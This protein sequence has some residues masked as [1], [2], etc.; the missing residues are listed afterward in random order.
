MTGNPAQRLVRRARRTRRQWSDRV[1]R[2]THELRSPEATAAPPA[3]ATA[4]EPAA[5]APRSDAQPP[6]EALTRALA[7]GR[8]L[9]HALTWQVRQLLAADE[10]DEAWA[11]AE[12]LRRRPDTATIG[13]VA[14]GIVA[15]R[16]GYVELA[17]DELRGVPRDVWTRLAA[18]AYI[19]A[20]LAVEPEA[21]LAELRA[22]V[23]DEPD[24]MPARSWFD[25]VSAAFGY[26]DDAL[27]RSA[28]A[29]LERRQRA[30][31]EDWPEGSRHL[32]WLRPWVAADGDSR[33]APEPPDGRRTFAIMDYGHPGVDRASANIGDHIQS[34]ASLGHLVRHQ[35]V[36]FHGPD[37]LVSVLG[38]LAA[39]T[40]PERRLDDV[41]AE[42]EV[43]TVHR[44]ASMYEA[45]PEDTW[46]LCFGW[47]MH[48]MFGMRHGFPLHRNLRPVFISFHCNKRDLLT[49]A[50]VEYLKRYGPVGCRDWTTVYLLLSMGVPAFFSGCVTTTIDTVFPEVPRP[51]ADAPVAYVDVPA[52]PDGKSYRH[53]SG[54]VRKRSFVANVR[55]AIDL[56]ETYR[57]RHGKVVTSRLHC[58]LPVRSLGVEVDF[59]PPNPADI[60]FDGLV[61]LDDR[62]FGAI[63]EGIDDKLGQV[64]R[65]VLSGRPEDEVYGLWRS[66]TEGAVA[67]AEKRR[68]AE[69]RLPSVIAEVGVQ[70]ERITA[71]T[72]PAPEGD[73]VHV[74]AMI[75]KWGV[76]G[77]HAL[78]DSLLE[79]AS[80][81]LHLWVLAL[82][83]LDE[84]LDA[85][86]AERFPDLSF[87]RVPLRGLGAGLVTPAGEQSRPKD[88]ARLLLADLLP[89]VDRLV[90]LPVPS[91]VE[92]DVAELAALDLGGRRLAAPTRPGRD[93]SG[94]AVVHAAALRLS[95]R[96]DAAAT[97]RRTA[98]ARHAFDFDAFTDEP[99]VLDLAGL[100]ADGFGD[101]ALRLVQ[102]YG[103][104]DLEV[105]HFV[106]G[107]DRAE[108]PAP[109]AVVPT[110][111]PV[112]TPKLVH[113]ADRIKPWQAL[114]TP[115][116]DRWRRHARG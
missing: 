99:L 23:A 94:F 108:I 105:L 101:E 54:V 110:R 76:R 62:E 30:E 107:A 92:A 95:A 4:A 87:S 78:I 113:W 112:G 63:R 29:A 47:Y 35:G 82:P 3:P 90:L 93:D 18:P 6:R 84:E 36:R 14:A 19:R 27:A 80:E 25:V 13:K 45:I 81:P 51:A 59:R 10:S 53:S 48:A 83:G 114:L 40:R 102:A 70:L 26:G 37:D 100:R 64:M 41:S 58:Y 91:V 75:N 79:H 66:L 115:E 20:G 103:L 89:G 32:E 21:T 116:R 71:E 88:V 60:R 1:Q 96:P 68:M 72:A 111:T 8:A 73:R 74:A 39:R 38:D 106:A 77:L 104:T 61:G 34:V 24:T 109:W 98:H 49:P 9:D 7:R 86:L 33:T 67:A 43:R 50:A 5:E 2:A 28:F 31:P 85:G 46:V 16:N 44:D 55:A 69:V 57:T 17:R 52:G 15:Y 22:L 12:S 97:L 42:L 65:A 56:L 11:L